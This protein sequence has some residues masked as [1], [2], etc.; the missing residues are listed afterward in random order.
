MFYNNNST[1][2]TQKIL[3]QTGNNSMAIW[4]YLK[5]PELLWKTFYC[6]TPSFTNYSI[7][8]FFVFEFHKR[9]VSIVLKNT[10]IKYLSLQIN[11]TY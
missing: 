9:V 4:Q 7:F 3:G 11:K 10:K 6:S 5:Q 8:I 1:P 2:G